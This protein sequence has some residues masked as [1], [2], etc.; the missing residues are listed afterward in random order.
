M[1]TLLTTQSQL[2][3]RTLQRPNAP[4]LF[5]GLELLKQTHISNCSIFKT[6][7]L[8]THCPSAVQFGLGAGD[9]KGGQLCARLLSTVTPVQVEIAKGVPGSCLQ[10]E[11]LWAVCSSVTVSTPLCH[12]ASFLFFHIQ[13]DASRIYFLPE[14]PVASPTTFLLSL[15][16]IK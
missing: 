10:G 8:G 15:L 1:G 6:S 16:E 7:S 4:W 12:R 3:L 13:N 14:V 2:H 5:R 11:P 9:R